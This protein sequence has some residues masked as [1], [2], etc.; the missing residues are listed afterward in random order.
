[1]ETAAPSGHA[2]KVCGSCGR[3]WPTWDDFVGD[4]QVRLLGLQAV[5]HLPEA[6][7]LVFEHRCGSSVSVLTRRLHHLLPEHP[8]LEWPSLRGTEACRRHCLSLAD[9]EACDRRCRH[10]LD[11]DLLALVSA[12][13]SGRRGG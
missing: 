8:A 10:A 7:V 3:P 9:H 2:F 12:A 1:M 5:P 11:R 6:S 13:G 4:P